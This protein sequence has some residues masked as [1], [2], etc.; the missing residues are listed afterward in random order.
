MG[1]PLGSAVTDG[2]KQPFLF[3]LSDHSKEP[4]SET[5]PV[6]ANLRSIYNRLPQHQRLWITLEGAGH[7]GFADLN[8][9]PL[10]VAQLLHLG[11]MGNQR[12]IEITRDCLRTF[13]DLYLRQSPASI[14]Q[15]L[16]KYPEIQFSR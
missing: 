11:P 6:Q 15:N 10:H 3:L 12:Q 7:F 16:S 1:A 5:V 4:K 14:S 2:V 9:L 13:F 8:P